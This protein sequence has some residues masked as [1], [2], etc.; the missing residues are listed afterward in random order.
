MYI[1]LEYPGV[2]SW[3]PIDVFDPPAVVVLAEDVDIEED[4]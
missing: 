3:H 1:P 4:C 2:E